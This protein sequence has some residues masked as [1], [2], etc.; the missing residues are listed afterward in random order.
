MRSSIGGTWLL[1]L[2]LVFI[3]L[4]VAFIILNLN[5]SKTVKVKDQALGIIERYEGL[6]AKSLEL[7]NTY[8][9]NNNYTAVGTCTGEAT[10]GIY[11]SSSLTDYYLEEAVPKKKYYYC[12]KK[13][14]G[15]SITNYY[16]F[17]FFYKFNLPVIGDTAGFVVR[18][19][20]SNFLAHDEDI[21]NKIIGG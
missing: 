19:T 6:N 4:F 5:Y 8:L 14:S 13:Y 1:S 15:I 12:V 10:S 16:Q 20:T 9:M 17:S 21:Y 2:M 18:G 7:L 11:G 3:T